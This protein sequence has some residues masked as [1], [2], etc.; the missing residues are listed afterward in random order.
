[1]EAKMIEPMPLWILVT[2]ISAT[3]IVGIFGMWLI[4]K[5]GD[6]P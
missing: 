1:M 5:I 3:L 6:D 4:S 2:V